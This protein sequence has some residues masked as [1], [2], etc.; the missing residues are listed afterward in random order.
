MGDININVQ[1][2]FF[3]A[4]PSQSNNSNIQQEASIS[5]NDTAQIHL[6]QDSVTISAQ[7]SQL[8][9]TDQIATDEL[10]E[11]G[12]TSKLNLIRE[13][14][15]SYLRETTKILNKRI[16][17]GNKLKERLFDIRDFAL[18]IQNN[19]E[20]T[21]VGITKFTDE[22]HSFVYRVFDDTESEAQY[23]REQK[24]ILADINA[25]ISF[26]G[27]ALSTEKARLIQVE[28]SSLLQISRM[29]GNILRNAGIQNLAVASQ[30]FNEIY[31]N[32]PRLPNNVYQLAQS[33]I[34]EDTQHNYPEAIVKNIMDELKVETQALNKRLADNTFIDTDLKTDLQE[35]SKP[36]DK[37][38]EDCQKLASRI[39]D[40]IILILKRLR[41]FSKSKNLNHQILWQLFNRNYI[42]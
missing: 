24:A 7:A 2:N 29:R 22:I 32:L 8:A 13:T 18:E 21:P 9:E 6:I 37:F 35:S 5:N 19:P 36:Y 40:I 31:N 12:Y 11:D 42:K 20:I 34:I 17:I 30:I 27:D 1:R 33:S 26:G 39:E 16:N 41:Y 23:I 14:K 15:D 10:L 3:S 25:S 4:L 38:S 28:M